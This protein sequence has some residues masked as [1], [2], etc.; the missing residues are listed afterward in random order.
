LACLEAAGIGW[1]SR[2]RSGTISQMS[3]SSKWGGR[4]VAL[5]QLRA[6][7]LDLRS[8]ARTKAQPPE[9]SL[10]A[11]AIQLGNRFLAPRM[12]AH[13]WVSNTPCS[14][15]NAAGALEKNFPR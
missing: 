3:F 2:K 14:V 1:L 5:R 4:P 6:L 12:A 10:T 9:A 8:S 15:C 7:P 11:L 13:S